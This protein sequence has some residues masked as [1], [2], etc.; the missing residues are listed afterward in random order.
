MSA[1]IT[2]YFYNYLH[3]KFIKSKI[4]NANNRLAPTPINIRLGLL[5]LFIHTK[6]NN[7]KYK[8]KNIDI[9]VIISILFTLI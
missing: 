2:D 1:N 3:N 8:S 7:I 9:T 4:A 6:D 5:V